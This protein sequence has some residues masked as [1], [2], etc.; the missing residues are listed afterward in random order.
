[1]NIEN[2]KIY[3]IVPI[4]KISLVV[5]TEVRYENTCS[6]IYQSNENNLVYNIKVN[7]NK[8][9]EDNRETQKKNIIAF[10]NDEGMLLDR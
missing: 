4:K 6:N 9:R 10:R 1:M 5:A 3:Q 8:L 2:S 7:R